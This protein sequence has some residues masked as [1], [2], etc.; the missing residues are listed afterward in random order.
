MLTTAELLNCILVVAKR[1]ATAPSGDS[2]FDLFGMCCL[3]DVLPWS[4]KEQDELFGYGGAPR[5]GI[6]SFVAI[7]DDHK[8]HR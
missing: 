1:S 2:R 7:L 5:H 4:S 8:S 6:S 3:L